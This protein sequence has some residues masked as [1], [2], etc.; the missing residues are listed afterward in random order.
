MTTQEERV[1]SAAE[2]MVKYTM[3]VNCMTNKQTNAKQ[4]TAIATVFAVCISTP[5]LKHSHFHSLSLSLSLSL[6]DIIY[7]SK[8]NN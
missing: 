6:S 7:A 8:Q 5:I 4:S 2:I 3:Q 1:R